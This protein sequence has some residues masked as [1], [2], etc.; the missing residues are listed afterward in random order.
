[1]PLTSQQEERARRLH[2]ESIVL[3]AHDH[4]FPPE[5]LEALRQGKVTAKILMAVLDARLRRIDVAAIPGLLLRLARLDALAKGIGRG[6]VWDDLA[7]L[8]LA[9]AGRPLPIEAVL[10]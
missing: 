10:S 5:D 4:F 7:D 6:R 8:A 1:M 9:L 3:L 2:E